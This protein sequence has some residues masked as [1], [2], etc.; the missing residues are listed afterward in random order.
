VSVRASTTNARAL[1]NTCPTGDVTVFWRGRP[2]V[3]NRTFDVMLW[4][5]EFPTGENYED[6]VMVMFGENGNRVEVWSHENFSSGFSYQQDADDAL[7]A[8]TTY[9]FALVLNTGTNQAGTLYA[10][11]VGSST[12]LGGTFT[13]GTLGTMGSDSFIVGNDYGDSAQQTRIEHM[14]VWNAQLS[15]AELLTERGHARA[16]R[17]T[18]LWGEYTLR[19]LVGGVLDLS[20]NNRDLTV[21]AELLAEAAVTSGVGVI[22]ADPFTAADA[23]ALGTH[24]AEWVNGWN[25]T[26]AINSGAAYK[27]TNN[28]NFG[29]YRR[30]VTLETNNQFAEGVVAA[31]TGGT[32]IGVAV[33]AT[34]SGGTASHYHFVGD[35]ADASY[36]NVVV[37]GEVTTLASAAAFSAGDRVR[38]EAE[39]STIRAFRNGTQVASVSNS[40]LSSGQV[41]VAA[42]GSGTGSRIDRW[43]GGDL[44]VSGGGGGGGGMIRRDRGGVMAGGMRDMRGGMSG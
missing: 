19:D 39:G 30:N 28:N 44:Y 26:F 9:D 22:L 16:I 3:V 8:N 11:A 7:S 15:E 32:Y 43:A 4:F 27:S 31:V 2:L 13:T 29:A 14:K 21:E 23:T 12:D 18:N 38:L 1:R 41:G 34:G 24:S 42:S 35:S 20:G 33:R 36:L 40:A 5:G 17:R 6:G 25:D 37:N 10:W